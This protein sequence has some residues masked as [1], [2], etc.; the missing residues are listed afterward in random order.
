MIEPMLQKFESL[1][2][3]SEDLRD[4][5]QQI[6]SV[7]EYPKKSCLL[8]EGHVAD[9]ACFVLKGLARAY[10]VSDG[11]EVTSRFMDE[12]FIITSWLSFYTRKPGYEII[13]TLEDSVLGCVN[14]D[15]LQKLYADFLEFNV[16][17]RKLTEYF[18]FLAEQRTQMLRKHTADEKYQFFL[19]QHPDLLQ[20]VQLKYI[21]T[22]LG[23]SEETLSRT[24]AKGIKG[25]K[26]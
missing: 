14:Y 16:I 20:R 19:A 18:F 5:L 2:P 7:K 11:R 6:I 12:G 25:V 1:Y 10:Y 8:Q 9:H 17:G 3:L 26:V 21:A 15:D 22:Y 23:M 13:E 4:R 24:R